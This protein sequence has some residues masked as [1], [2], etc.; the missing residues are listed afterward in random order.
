MVGLQD[1]HLGPEVQ[2]ELREGLT[3]HFHPM[4]NLLSSLS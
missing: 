1:E 2:R 3:E 4:N